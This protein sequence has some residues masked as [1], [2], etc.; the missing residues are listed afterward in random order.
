VFFGAWPLF[1]PEHRH[2]HLSRHA[3]SAEPPQRR[4]RRDTAT[5][6]PSLPAPSIPACSAAIIAPRSR[7]VDPIPLRG[8]GTR[9]GFKRIICRPAPPGHRDRRERRTPCHRCQPVPLV[10][11]AELRRLAADAVRVTTVGPHAL[12]GRRG[13]R[14]RRSWTFQNDRGGYT[15]DSGSPYRLWFLLRASLGV[16]NLIQRDGLDCDGLLHEPEEELAPAL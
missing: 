14:E 11:R 13:G 5:L 7:V 6:R 15:L 8:P 3:G 4:E 12:P 16:K 1:L 9:V 2:H 10:Q